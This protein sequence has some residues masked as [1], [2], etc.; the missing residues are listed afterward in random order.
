MV[1]KLLEEANKLLPEAAPVRTVSNPGRLER[2]LTALFARGAAPTQDPTVGLPVHGLNLG[3][4]EE[5]GL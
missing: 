1:E 4:Q 3:G 2:R 5:D